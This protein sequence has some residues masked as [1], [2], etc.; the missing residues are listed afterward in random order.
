MTMIKIMMKLVKRA[1]HEQNRPWNLS[2][3]RNHL[4]LIT[5]HHSDYHVLFCAKGL[6]HFYYNGGI[7]NWEPGEHSGFCYGTYQ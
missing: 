7:Q 1:R 2:V 6:C 5:L 4:V 3:T